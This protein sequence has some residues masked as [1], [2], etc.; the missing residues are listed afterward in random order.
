MSSDVEG[1]AWPPKRPKCVCI[2]VCSSRFTFCAPGVCGTRHAKTPA[3]IE[4]PLFGKI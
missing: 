1:R 3:R 4:V 2:C